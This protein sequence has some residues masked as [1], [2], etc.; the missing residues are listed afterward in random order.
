M[1]VLILYIIRIIRLPYSKTGRGY[2][3]ERTQLS[4]IR[5]TGLFYF[6]AS[7]LCEASPKNIQGSTL[8][9]DSHIRLA[10]FQWLEKQ[11]P[12]YEEVFPRSILEKGFTLEGT[13]IPL[14]SPQGIF[15]PRRMT[16]P[17]SITTTPN[18]PYDDSLYEEG[19]LDYKYRGA[20]INHRDNAGLH[21]AM[22]HHIPLIYFYGIMP[23]KYLAIWPVYI[24]FNNPA[25]LS[26]KVA[27]DDK[28]ALA[29]LHESTIADGEAEARR[30]YI[31]ASVKA[32][33]HQKSFREKVL[34]AY[35]NQCAF[36]R[37][38]HQ[39]LLDAAHIL[40]DNDPDGRPSITNGISL[41][42]IH[43]AAFD[44]LF[45]GIRP[46]YIIEVRADILKESDG[47]MLLH[48]LQELH[49]HAIILPAAKQ[50]WP[51]AEY[52][53]RRYQQFRKTG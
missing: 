21:Q 37:L 8:D 24:A 46:D 53:H 29:P 34:Y 31:I 6:P 36:C 41:C 5:S 27:V 25:A 51:K 15:R 43:H 44:K 38:K 12:F 40:P 47:P 18:G 10:A 39:E 52:L 2:G 17:L 35:R 14:V 50:D 28:N 7:S 13:R 4:K 23:G 22:L 48:G 42:K 11:S 16:Y 30:R 20:D 1:F 3:G 33:L 32:R 9:L 19:F 45:I 49:G 26:F